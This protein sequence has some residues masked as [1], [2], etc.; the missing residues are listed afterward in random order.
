MKNF[1][2]VL[3]IGQ[4]ANLDEIKKAYREAAKRYHPDVSAKPKDEQKFLEVLEAYETLSDPE[5]RSLYDQSLNEKVRRPYI[6]PPFFSPNE[7]VEAKPDLFSEI[8]RIFTPHSFLSFYEVKEADLYIEIL[9]TFEEAQR[10]G[11]FFLKIPVWQKCSR[12]NGS[13]IRRDLICGLCRGQGK[14]RIEKKI[15]LNIPPGI[16]DGMRVRFKAS[17]EREVEDLILIFRVSEGW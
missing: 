11:H 10:G 1:Y 17:L 12:C 14:R 3:G 6:K 4:D 9:L 15:E 2:Q 13:G 8:D 7:S 5:R 16:R